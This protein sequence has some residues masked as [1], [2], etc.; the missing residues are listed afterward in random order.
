MLT[1]LDLLQIDQKV[2]ELVRTEN[3]FHGSITVPCS[4]GCTTDEWLD[5]FV[6][7][8]RNRGFTVKEDPKLHIFKLP[9]SPRGRRLRTGAM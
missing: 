8:L 7:E 4:A 5:R 2:E 9:P 3:D 6:L 1:A